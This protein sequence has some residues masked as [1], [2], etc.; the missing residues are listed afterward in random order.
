MTRE[1]VHELEGP[2]DLIYIDAWK[3]HYVDYYD[4]VLPKLAPQGLIAADD[5][6]WGGLPFNDK[7][8][9]IES[10]GIRRFVRH[11][12]DDPRVHNVLLT[13]GEGLLLIWRAPE[14]ERPTSPNRHPGGTAPRAEQ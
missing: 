10:E 6:I 8:T 14:S 2:F 12:Q 3:A 13:V 5:V 7:A 1:L 4:A 9:D 11:V